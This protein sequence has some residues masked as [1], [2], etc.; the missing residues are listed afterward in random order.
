MLFKGF[1]N[2]LFLLPTNDHSEQLEQLEQS[3]RSVSSTCFT[4]IK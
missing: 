2:R 4:R 1:E 3:W